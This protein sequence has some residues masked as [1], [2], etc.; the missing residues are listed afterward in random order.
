[1]NNRARNND[2]MVPRYLSMSWTAVIS[3]AFTSVS[4]SILMNLFN[5]GLGFSAYA[6]G[7]N[8]EAVAVTTLIW[9]VFTVF[10]VM[11]ASGFVSGYIA[12][13]RNNS[14]CS[15][16]THG[17]LSWCIG[18]I[19]M[20]ILTGYLSIIL[21]VN[22]QA[23]TDLTSTQVETAQ[24]QDDQTTIG[25][26]KDRRNHNFKNDRIIVDKQT[27]AA[28]LAMLSLQAFFMLLV[29]AFASILG[30]HLGIRFNDDELPSTI[31]GIK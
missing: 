27:L 4:L 23:I 14:W 26:I 31:A 19:M 10:L 11:F 1:M 16:A 28:R 12:R 29:A 3:G 24:I 20:L 13:Y 5:M 18:L 21:P 9:T 22:L 30:G 7:G 2:D 8:I 25:T 6:A 17:F 15:G